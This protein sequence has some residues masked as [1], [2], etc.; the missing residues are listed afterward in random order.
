MYN[1]MKCEVMKLKRSLPLRIL[2]GLM[3]GCVLYTS[4]AAV[5]L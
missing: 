1:L 3:G 2:S 4:L 5:E